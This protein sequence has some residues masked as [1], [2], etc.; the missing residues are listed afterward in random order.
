[1]GY[2][3]SNNIYLE[4]ELFTVSFEERIDNSVSLT[5]F[6]KVLDFPKEYF[7]IHVGVSTHTP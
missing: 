7:K 3:Y 4:V 6:G 5:I 2:I 1:V